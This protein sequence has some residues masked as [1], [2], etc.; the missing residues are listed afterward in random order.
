LTPYVAAPTGAPSTSTCTP[1]IGVPIVVTSSIAQPATV[2]VPETVVPGDGM[3]MWTD[4]ITA[5]VTVTVTLVEPVSGGLVES[6]AV[7]VMV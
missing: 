7:T 5:A 3:S 6:V 2:T 4:G 1:L